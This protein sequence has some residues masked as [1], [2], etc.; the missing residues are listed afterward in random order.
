MENWIGHTD[1]DIILSIEEN[2]PSTASTSVVPDLWPQLHPRLFDDQSFKKAIHNSNFLHL[3]EMLEQLFPVADLLPVFNDASSQTLLEFITD[4]PAHLNAQAAAWRILIGHVLDG[5]VTLPDNM[6]K[7]R[8]LDKKEGAKITERLQMLQNI[9]TLSDA[10]FPYRLQ[11]RL[12]LSTLQ[13]DSW[14][15]AATT[16]SI[17]FYLNDIIGTGTDWFSL[18]PSVAPVDLSKPV[19]VVVVDAIPVDV[20]LSLLTDHSGLFSS[21]KH[22]WFRQVVSSSTLSGL[23]ELFGFPE[24]SDPQNELTSRSVPYTTID[25]DEEHAWI[26]MIPD[27]KNSLSQ[28]VRVSLFDR[29]VH[30]GTF[31]LSGLAEKL[32]VLLM[33]HLPELIKQCKKNK[34]HL[35]LTT[36]HGLSLSE[37]GLH[38]GSGGLYEQTIFRAT[39]Q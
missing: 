1:G 18:L 37:K 30:V 10:P 38:H 21:A 3:S 6:P 19:T 27:M 32:P 9:T 26:D 12:L 23:N 17:H 13:N 5:K 34:R 4:E 7:V 2:T 14:T 15:D 36:D 11:Q 33:R 25:G 22:Q 20:W 35:V 24:K 31:N 29:G 8:C 39:W 28:V 16:R